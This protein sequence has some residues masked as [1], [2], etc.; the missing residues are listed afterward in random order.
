M[1]ACISVAKKLEIYRGQ[2]CFH[3]LERPIYIDTAVFPPLSSLGDRGSVQLLM[4]I[5][6]VTVT[7][8]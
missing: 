8:T 4:K 6:F 3:E 2:N 1:L 5:S 7:F